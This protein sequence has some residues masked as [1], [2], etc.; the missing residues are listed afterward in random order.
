VDLKLF[1]TLVKFAFF[2]KCKTVEKIENAKSFKEG[3]YMLHQL[4]HYDNREITCVYSV[5]QECE[6]NA[7]IVQ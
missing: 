6:N 7:G 2:D 1:F 4:R 3:L 5:R